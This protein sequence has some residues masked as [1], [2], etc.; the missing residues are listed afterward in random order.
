MPL[1]KL[2]ERALQANLIEELGLEDLPDHEKEKIILQ[3]GELI[4]QNI[5]LRLLEELPD[6]A[7]DELEA[8]VSTPDDQ[9]DKLRMFYAKY[10]PNMEELVKEEIATYKE[11]LIRTFKQ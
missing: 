6:E 2:Q 9:T 8:I 4:D 3:V 10:V 1:T 5:Y 11:N 7:L